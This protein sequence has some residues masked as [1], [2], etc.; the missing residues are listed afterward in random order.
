MKI[1]NLIPAPTNAN[2]TNNLRS[3]TARTP[4]NQQ[5]PTIKIDQILPDSSKL[6]FYF[7]KLTT[8]QLT[9]QTACLTRSRRSAC[10]RSMARF[11]G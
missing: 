6:S 1:Q 4:N 3:S 10:R 9:T 5:I 7:N 8:N 11:R 2:Q